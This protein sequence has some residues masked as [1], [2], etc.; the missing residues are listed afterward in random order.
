M[1]KHLTSDD[2]YDK[3]TGCL[4][5]AKKPHDMDEQKWIRRM[6]KINYS[7]PALQTIV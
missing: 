7:L 4:R 3:Q 2:V 6:K 1:N 5:E